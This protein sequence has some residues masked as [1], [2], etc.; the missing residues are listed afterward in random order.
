NL[1][2]QYQF[3]TGEDGVDP[4]DPSESDADRRPAVAPDDLIALLTRTKPVTPEGPAGPVHQTVL[5]RLAK[6][7]GLIRGRLT[8]TG[9]H[10]I[11]CPWCRDAGEFGINPPGVLGHLLGVET[12]TVVMGAA[13]GYR[14]GG[15]HCF[16]SNC[17]GT[18]DAWLAWAREHHRDWLDEID[19]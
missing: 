12:R 14:I 18:I 17:P 4:F 10:P 8:R 15:F 16:S 3:L 2:G 13:P 5:A 19:A 11:T 6:R 7:Q 1:K 9:H